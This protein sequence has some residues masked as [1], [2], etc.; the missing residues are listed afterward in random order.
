MIVGGGTR[1]E[2]HTKPRDGSGDPYYDCS[3]PPRKTRT[4]YTG[5]EGPRTSGRR[6]SLGSNGV[7]NRKRWNAPVSKAHTEPE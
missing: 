1:V 7:D 6:V 2:G 5:T 3:L 4:D